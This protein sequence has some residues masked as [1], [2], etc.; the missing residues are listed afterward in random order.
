[1]GAERILMIGLGAAAMLVL[2][3]ARRKQF[4]EVALWKIPVLM[5]ML[6]V[7]GVLGTMILFFF[8]SGRIG[9]TSFYGAVLLVPILM[10]PALALRIK[11]HTLMDLCAAAECAMLAVMKIDCV[12]GGCCE[13]K[14]VPELGIQFPSQIVEGINALG[15]AILLVMIYRKFRCGSQYPL[16][17]IFY[18]ITRFFLNLMRYTADDP[19]ILGMAQGNFWSLVSIALGAVWLAWL[20]RDRLQKK[21]QKGKK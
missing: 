12:M 19:H 11:F 10:L 7:A 8:E 4:P 6:T 20:Y 5:V 1:M 13:G 15:L 21:P 9:G 16:Y 18:G 14:Y 2:T 17:L 3:L